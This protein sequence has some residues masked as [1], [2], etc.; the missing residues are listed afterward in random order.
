M[1]Q[2]VKV[3]DEDS[4]MDAGKDISS[5]IK[6]LDD[7]L[8][9]DIREVRVDIKKL[10]EK[11]DGR[12]DAL[13]EDIKDLDKNLRGEIKDLDKNLRGEIRYLDVKI[14]K[15]LTWA[16]S[17]LVVG[18]AILGLLIKVPSFPFVN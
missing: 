2:P 7:R 10:D 18:I 12:T 14:G 17:I 13:R 11:F 3:R 4:T 6:R 8:T 9:S 5:D 15:N 1:A 16:V